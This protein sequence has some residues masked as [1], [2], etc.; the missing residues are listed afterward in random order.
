MGLAPYGEPKFE[1]KIKKIVDIKAD[2]SF[3]LDQ[4]YFDYATGLTMTNKKFEVLFGQKKPRKPETEKISQFHMDIAAS[5]QKVTEDI[6]LKLVSSIKEEYKLDNLCL[7]GGVALNCVANG[8]LLEKKIFG[9]Y[10]GS[11]SGRRCWRIFRRCVSF[12]VY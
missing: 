12:L 4:S 3:R 9:K 11:A 5:I 8:K 6:M 10:L 2:G 1:D 7:A